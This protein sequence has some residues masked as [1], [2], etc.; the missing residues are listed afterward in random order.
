MT[1]TNLTPTRRNADA[2]VSLIEVLVAVLVF[3]IISTGIVAGMTTIARMTTDSRARITAANL[4]TQDIDLVRSISDP[5]GITNATSTVTVDGRDYTVKRSTSWVSK[6][7]ADVSCGSSTNLLFL[8]V[9][10]R[11]SW[12]G[13]LA[14][15]APAQD[16]TII[17]PAGRISDTSSGSIGVSVVG[18]A[19]DPQSGVAVSVTPTTGGKAL[20]TTPDPTNANGCTYVNEVSPGTYD[21]TISK[22][23]WIDAELQGASATESATVTAGT[24]QSPGFP[25]YAQAATF[26]TKYV[27]GPVDY[28]AAYALPTNLETTWTNTSGTWTTPAPVASLQRFPYTSGYGVIAGATQSGGKTCQ[29]VDPQAWGA[30]TSNGVA[31]ASGV[32]ATAAAAAGQTATVNIPVGV[33]LV[34]AP[35]GNMLGATQATPLAGNPSCAVTNTIYTFSG[36]TTGSWQ[37]IALPYGSWRIYYG[38]SVNSATAIGAASLQVKTNAAGSGVAADG[39]VTLDP[40][41]AK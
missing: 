1:R 4:A 7:G 41:L 21:V 15:S 34:K 8:R 2:G 10:T 24:T 29:S 13:M 40:R 11:V 16:D 32:R 17:A 20:T 30:G 3:A 36:T 12:A 9:N 28:P 35:A 23:G 39:T 25:L 22:A 27:D 33:L 19:A 6:A 26:T 37:A 31:L 5:F 14:T 38:T 18:A